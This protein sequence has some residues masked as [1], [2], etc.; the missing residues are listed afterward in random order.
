MALSDLQKRIMRRLAAN[1]SQTSYLAGGLVLNRDWARRSDDIDIFHDADEEVSRTAG[2]DIADLQAD[3]FHVHV[4]VKAF[5]TFEATV[6]DNTSS[7]VI[8]WMSDTRIRFP[9]GEGR[10]VG[11]P[12]TSG[13]SRREQDSCCS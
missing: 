1:R 9:T 5:G 7:T 10:A 11:A 2:K 13:R 3:G 12:L 8:Q 6:S 4:D